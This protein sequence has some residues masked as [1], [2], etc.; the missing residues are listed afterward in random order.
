MW[1]AG[2]V[3]R[4]LLFPME[5][6]TAG[7]APIVNSTMDFRRWRQNLACNIFVPREGYQL[8]SKHAHV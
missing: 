3:T 4:I 7:I 1:T 8:L 5:I 6:G 2:F